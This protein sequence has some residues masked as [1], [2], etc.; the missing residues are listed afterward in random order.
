MICFGQTQESVEKTERS[1]KVIKQ[2]QV[3]GSC[4]GLDL[5]KAGFTVRSI[6]IDDPFD[7][8]P[9]AKTRQKRAAAQITALI[10]D[11][12]FTY[13]DAADKALEIIE[14]ENFL[15]DTSD[16]RIKFRI[17]LVSVANCTGGKVDLIYRIYSTQIRPVLS[18]RPEQRVKERESPQDAAGQT[19]VIAEN[20]QSL[21]SCRKRWTEANQ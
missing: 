12:P 18:A 8:L 2:D 4:E 3:A 9:W 10:K 15:P 16:A 14:K 6:R 17:E 5:E 19:T 11:K 1:N 20:V 21:H 7:F 13:S